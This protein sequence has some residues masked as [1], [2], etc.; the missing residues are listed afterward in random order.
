MVIHAISPHCSPAHFLWRVLLLEPS[1]IKAGEMTYTPG[2]HNL[3][4]GACYGRRAS[5]AMAPLARHLLTI[6]IALYLETHGI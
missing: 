2:R 6:S 4:D 3:K 1:P 5:A